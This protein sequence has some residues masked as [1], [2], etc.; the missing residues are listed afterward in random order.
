LKRDLSRAIDL[1]QQALAK[2]PANAIEQR[3]VPSYVL[4]YSALILGQVGFAANVLTPIHLALQGSSDMLLVLAVAGGVARAM[5]LQGQLQRAAVLYQDVIRR[6]AG[7]THQEQP[8]VYFYLGR[9]YYEWNDLASA[10]RMLHEGILIGQRTGRGRFWPSAY[11]V[12]AWVGWARGDASDSTSLMEQALT[13][14]RALNSSPTITEVEARQAGLWLAQGDLTAAVRWLAGRALDAEAQIPYEYQAEYLVLARIRIAQE[15]QV[16]GSGELDAVVRLL[17][18]L[19][20]MAE[21]DGRA[22]DELMILALLA[23]AHAARGDSSQALVLLEAALALA[24][25]EGYIRTFVDE[26][27]PM[28]SLLVR[29]CAQLSH[30]EYGTRLRRYIDR[31]LQAF[32]SIDGADLPAS[33]APSLLS[34]REHT[35]L[36]LLA[37]GRSIHEIASLLIISVHT[38]RTH[39]KHIYA[40][41]EAHN[42]VQA[43]EYAR[44]LQLL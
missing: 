41:L 35:I 23:L 34:Q 13:S 9:L 15:R 6:A 25:P 27:L 19:L 22:S 40:K 26:G 20:H 11:A 44:A 7:A 42:R 30:S 8:A 37:D 43:L 38:A 18:R 31:V 17:E 3:G 33:G 29:Q 24:E 39:V 2:I 5:Q 10:E 32:S 12:L 21:A 28:R 1:A 4:S 14:A 36:Q 16:P